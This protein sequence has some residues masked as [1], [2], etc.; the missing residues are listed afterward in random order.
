MR[1]RL[2]HFCYAWRMQSWPSAQFPPVAAITTAARPT[3]WL[4]NPQGLQEV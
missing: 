1:P 2:L 3:M 4:G